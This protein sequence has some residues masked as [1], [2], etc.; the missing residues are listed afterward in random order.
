MAKIFKLWMPLLALLCV[1]SLNATEIARWNFT[2][3]SGTVAADSIGSSNLNL[4]NMNNSNWSVDTPSGKGYSLQFDGV[5]DYLSLANQDSIILQSTGN[6]S[7]SLWY[8][9]AET[10][11]N[12]V[13]SLLQRGLISWD[14]GAIYATLELNAG[15]PTYNH[16]DGTWNSNIMGSASVA[17][18]Q[19]H[20]IT[21][22][23]QSNQTGYLYVDGVL[24]SSGQSI[25]SQNNYG[26]RLNQFMRTYIGVYTA[27]QLYDI[28]VFNNALTQQT[29][30]TL[31]QETA[32]VA[33]PE[34]ASY[35][36]VGLF[37]VGAFFYRLKVD[38]SRQLLLAWQP[39]KKILLALLVLGSCSFSSAEGILWS[40]NFSTN[41]LD[42]YTALG[43]YYP[44]ARTISDWS[45]SGGK[46]YAAF[47]P[48]GMLA[49]EDAQGNLLATPDHFS[50]SFS[51]M[52]IYPETQAPYE[53]D[54]P[55]IAFDRNASIARELYLRPH[56]NEVVGAFSSNNTMT[57]A[58]VKATSGLAVHSSYDLFYE[59]NY[60]D[61]TATVIIRGLGG[62]ALIHTATLS[63]T[64]FTNAFGSVNT[65][66]A[67][68]LVGFSTEGAAF[69][70][71]VVRDYA[72]PEPATFFT[73]LLT[74]LGI[75]G[76]RL[77]G[78]VH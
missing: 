52:P 37:L 46:L 33:V 20:N 73:L 3:G 45:I 54:H 16:Y 5:D 48:T 7:V 50:I 66:G 35:V 21:L 70:N 27:G 74:I 32:A 14:S 34:P 31:I 17:N 19:W 72:V 78:R 36:F 63:G 51:Y 18:N 41:T 43:L 65:K 1:I 23:N 30:N 76:L 9:G 39:V 26:F 77:S 22:V 44:T 57:F 10:R 12:P 25:I 11:S 67:F 64:Q 40:D 15:R 55:G 62:G 42:R 69:D 71:L 56:S 6:F 29:V 28:R 47:G 61:Q 59:V 4:I 8:K 60:L 49:L 53:Q 75:C 38:R 2:Q 24:V 68:G 58:T 13:T